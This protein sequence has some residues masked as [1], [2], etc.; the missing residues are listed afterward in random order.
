M[1]KLEGA[2]L[3]ERM[4]LNIGAGVSQGNRLLDRG[5]NGRGRGHRGLAQLPT[6]SERLLAPSVGYS[7]HH[8]DVSLPDSPMWAT[9]SVTRPAQNRTS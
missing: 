5:G 6:S 2:P 4:A 8:V 9:S 3:R 7:A 1:I